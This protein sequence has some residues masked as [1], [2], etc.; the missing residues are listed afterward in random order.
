MNEKVENTV[1]EKVEEVNYPFVVYV[2][3]EG[4][5]K[6]YTFGSFHNDYEPGTHVVVE[7]V[8]GLEMGEVVGNP[9][10][11]EEISNPLPLKPIIRKATPKDEEDLI[12]NKE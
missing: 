5:K 3:F 6:A 2:R 1:E 8:R 10:R 12:K 7:T 11:K 9:K 4:T